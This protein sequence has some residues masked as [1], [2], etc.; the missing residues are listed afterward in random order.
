[1]AGSL[2]QYAERA[3]LDHFFKVSSF[4]QP[5]NIYMA[6]SIAD[7]TNDGSGFS[8]PSGNDYARV[9]V[10]TWDGA[11]T[12]GANAITANT[13]A[14][15][16]PTAT[17]DYAADVT[18]WAL[19][20][21][22]SGGNMLW[23]GD[24]NEGATA[25]VTDDVPQFA[26]GAIDLTLSGKFSDAINIDLLDHLMKGGAFSV[27]TD[28]YVALS[29]ADPAANGGSIAEPSGDGYARVLNNTWDAASSGAPSETANTGT[30]TFPAAS[31]SWGTITWMALFSA[32]SG[33][34]YYGRA[35]LITPRAVVSGNVPRFAAGTLLWTA[36]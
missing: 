18:H 2:S 3:L 16:F 28:L 19:F 17:G 27:P 20:D 13:G 6:L 9:Q 25:I 33:G 8:E 10:N 31:G 22:S 14:I 5:S 35:Q 4:T 32:S 21:A 29:T 26:A 36:E 12:S 7:P 24:I 23:Y 1:M 34:T 15:T 11:S 30:V